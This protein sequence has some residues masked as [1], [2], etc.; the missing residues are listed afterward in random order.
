MTSQN[1]FS[2]I[3]E[4]DIN[5]NPVQE[6]KKRGFFAWLFGSKPEAQIT[7][8]QFANTS[9]NREKVQGILN[10]ALTVQ[11]EETMRKQLFDE[12]VKSKQNYDLKNESEKKFY[13]GVVTGFLTDFEKA[14]NKL[15]VLSTKMTQVKV[16]NMTPADKKDNELEVVINVQQNNIAA[17]YAR[18]GTYMKE[19][20]A[21]INRTK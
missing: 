8:V 9:P 1:P 7:S 3:T 13:V 18:I 15:N 20:A 17:L 5:L 4:A 14:R 6:Q 19:V 11:T 10:E 16:D 2:N 21:E 12:T